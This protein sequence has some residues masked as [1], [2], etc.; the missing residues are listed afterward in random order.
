MFKVLL[1]GVLFCVSIS[2]KL[3]LT[4]N[5]LQRIEINV[6]C[7]RLCS[8][9]QYIRILSKI[10]LRFLFP[11]QLNHKVHKDCGVLP[12]ECEQIST[13]I[14]VIILIFIKSHNKT[15]PTKHHN[16]IFLQKCMK[17]IN[18]IFSRLFS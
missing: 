9:I 3:F 16:V 6:R 12:H 2:S 13:F 10:N 11:S 14:V 7:I 18:T 5:L 8:A 4:R 15:Q 17:T 1:L